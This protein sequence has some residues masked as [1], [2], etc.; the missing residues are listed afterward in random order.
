[1]DNKRI[2]ELVKNA[3]SRDGIQ[4]MYIVENGFALQ[5]YKTII[6]AINETKE[7]AAI[8]CEKIMESAYESGEGATDIPAWI[9]DCIREIRASKIKE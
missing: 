6:T 2:Q 7:D 8:I 5:I 1:M 3:I 4:D 9:N